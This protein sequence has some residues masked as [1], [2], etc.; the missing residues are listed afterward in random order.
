MTDKDTNDAEKLSERQ[1]KAIPYLVACPTFE[2]GRK[3]AKISRNALYDWLKNP[4]FKG[5]LKKARDSVFAE[6]L[7]TLK[8]N[9]SKAVETLIKLLEDSENT[10][11]KRLVCNDIINHTLRA[12]EI[13]DI[14]ERLS[15]I[16]RTILERSY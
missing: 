14:E 16:E 6:S 9:I 8:G 11:L 13:M 4:L 3:K 10:S 15:S 7:E 1:L 2:E 12:K 5:E